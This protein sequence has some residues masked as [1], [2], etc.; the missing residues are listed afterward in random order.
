MKI[1]I[2]A[3]QWHEEITNGLLAGA[4]R[5]LA[6]AGVEV[7]EIRVPGS[8]ELPV[9]SKAALEAGVRLRP[10]GR[11]RLA[12]QAGDDEPGDDAIQGAGARGLRPGGV[13]GRDAGRR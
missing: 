3:G 4:R 6:E 8:F 9:V 1:T 10:A 13:G 7:S 5:A 12:N 11:A 2:V